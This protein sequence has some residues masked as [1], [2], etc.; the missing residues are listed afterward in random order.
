MADVRP[1]R[2]LRYNPQLVGTL[3][4]IICPPYDIITPEVQSVLYQRSPYNM[5]RL[6]AGQSLPSDTASN[7]SYTRTT[8]VY[9]TLMEEGALVRDAEPAFY[10]VR[11]GF[12]FKGKVTAQLGL[13]ACVRLEEYGSKVILP[14]ERTRTEAIS[15][16]LALME[17]CHANFS[18]VMSLYRDREAKLSPIFQE[19]MSGAPLVAFSS[20]EDQEFSLWE[21]K[22]PLHVDRISEV[23]ANKTL[24]LADGHHRYET[25]LRYRNMVKSRSQSP[26][27]PDDAVNFVLMALIE[28]NDPGLMLLPYH[29][30][31]GGLDPHLLGKIQDRLNELFDM[32]PF[33]RDAEW[34]I[35]ALLEE[36]EER[37]R[38]G[39]I[40]GI[41]GPGGEG[42]YLLT[43]RDTGNLKKRGPI[44][45][46]E[47]WILEEMVFKQVLGDSG[48]HNLTWVHDAANAVEKVRTGQQ[49]MALFLKPLPLALFENVVR[50]GKLL[51]PKSTFF[52]PK[53]P[54]GLVLNP[55]EGTI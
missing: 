52:Y 20:S 31:I 2:A 49:Q 6:E 14:H 18:H 15:D 19:V 17:A 22:G 39:P 38:E 21:I 23:L 36:I 26:I 34:D 32:Y 44:S 55:L 40:V 29:R 27:Q 8:V 35:E 30:L 9:H 53:L 46:F 1:F 10:L 54:A 16:R 28:M 48:A 42:P 4:N 41:L 11:Y 37:G 3:A 13:L 51:P 50:Q 33:S 47:G 45:S 5:V 43:L 7:N 24:Y 25:A 12:R